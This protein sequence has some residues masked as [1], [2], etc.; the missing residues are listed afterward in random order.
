MKKVFAVIS[1][2]ISLIGLAGE[3]RADAVVPCSAD[4][5]T[6]LPISSAG[7]PLE[8]KATEM[9]REEM[10]NLWSITTT[11]TGAYLYLGKVIGAGQDW[12]GACKFPGLGIATGSGGGIWERRNVTLWVW[13]DG[14]DMTQARA[15]IYQLVGPAP[16]TTTT[17]TTSTTTIPET[18]TTTTTAP[19][20]TTTTIPETTTTSPTPET[21]T[22]VPETTT[23]VVDAGISLAVMPP[24]TMI[25][26][27]A[28]LEGAPVT[29][30]PQAPT[31][32]AVRQSASVKYQVAQPQSAKL[33]V[34]KPVKKKVKVKAKHG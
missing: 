30:M 7:T 10:T 19:E 21:T 4:V 11:M 31:V 20:T 8:F 23:T 27:Y 1:M 34:V 13:A 32:D 12:F 17:T 26:S 15:S 18:T 6:M 22:T 3:L 16:V 9:T 29:T 28:G 14:V 24:E 33:K 25:Y 2:V 5:A